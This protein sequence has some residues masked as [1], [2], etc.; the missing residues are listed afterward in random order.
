[1]AHIQYFTGH[2]ALSSNLHLSGDKG[3][4]KRNGSLTD[5][6]WHEVMP[7]AYL[8]SKKVSNPYH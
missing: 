6:I 5:D 7:Q 3:M 2:Q 4:N 1:M 8:L